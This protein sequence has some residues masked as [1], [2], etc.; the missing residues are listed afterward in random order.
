MLTIYLTASTSFVTRKESGVLSP[1]FA[2]QNTKDTPQAVE[3][4]RKVLYYVSLI[5]CGRFHTAISGI[6]AGCG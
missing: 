6:G 2:P 3:P 4:K 1:N 5:Y